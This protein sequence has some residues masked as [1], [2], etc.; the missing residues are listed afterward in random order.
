MPLNPAELLTGASPPAAYG[1]IAALV[2]SESVLLLGAF[3]PTLS[4][5]LCAG[6]LSRTGTLWLPAVVLCAAA[7]AAVGDLLAHRTGRRLGPGLRSCRLGRRVPD[8][9][10]DR[11]WSA[12]R[13]RGG[14]ALFLSRFLPV[15]RTV[16][17]HVAGAAGVPYARLAPYS[18]AAGAVWACLET[19]AGYAAGSAYGQLFGALG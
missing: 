8:T 1:V 14:P 17:P 13:R 9:A 6:F 15:V 3:V 11:A 7:G 19:V 16:A 18:M 4:L 12:V 5:L 10:W 2:T